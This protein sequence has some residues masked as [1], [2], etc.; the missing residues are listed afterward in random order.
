MPATPS[1]ATIVEGQHPERCGHCKN[2]HICS[3]HIFVYR[4][5][6]EVFVPLCN[7]CADDLDALIMDF[8]AAG[9]TLSISAD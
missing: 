7:T 9:V 2:L 8:A 5:G 6:T 1:S 3:R 4:Y